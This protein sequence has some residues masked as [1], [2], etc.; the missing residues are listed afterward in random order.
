[1]IW[2]I[3]FTIV[4]FVLFIYILLLKMIKKNDT[5]YLI[6][7]GIQAIGILLNL[8]KI[9]FNTLNRYIKYNNTISIKY[10]NTNSS[11]YIRK[12]KYKHF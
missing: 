4:A 1:M 11:I 5:T 3:T 8:I 9:Y 6:I 2:E 12:K 7:L 10:N